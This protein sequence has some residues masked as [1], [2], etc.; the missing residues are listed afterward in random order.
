VKK[1]VSGIAIGFLMLAFLMFCVI[2]LVITIRQENTCWRAGYEIPINYAGQTWCF[3]Y[4]GE[5]I[6]VAL[7]DVDQ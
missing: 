4:Q 6:A 7:D 1:T 2:S 5:A 3:G